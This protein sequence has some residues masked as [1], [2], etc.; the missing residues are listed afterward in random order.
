[1][2]FSKKIALEFDLSCIIGKDDNSFFRKYD[3]NPSQ[4]MKDDLSQINTQN[5]DIFFK[6]TEKMVF[7]KRIAPGHDLSC[8]IWKGGIFFPKAWYFFHGLKT[9]E[10]WT[11]SRNTRKQDIFYLICSRPPPAKKNQG[12]SYSTK[13]NLKVIDITDRHPTKSSSN[14]LYFHG[15]L[16]KRFHMLLSNNKKQQKTGNWIYRI[17]VLFDWRYSTIN[18]LQYFVPFIPQQ[19]Y[20]EACLSANQGK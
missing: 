4:K 2:V 16:Y 13:I 7:S 19:L 18:N 5:Y 1:M 6:C 8:T 3:L 11:L 15:G 9:G 17:E 12:R 20:L 14:S 10:G